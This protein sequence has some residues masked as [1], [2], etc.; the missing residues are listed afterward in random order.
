MKGL[1]KFLYALVLIFLLSA[2]LLLVKY[3][4]E[5]ITFPYREN[6]LDLAL[7]LK[8][9]NIILLGYLTFYLLKFLKALSHSISQNNLFSKN[10]GKAFHSIGI[11]LVFYSVLK[12]IISS[13]E[14]FVKAVQLESYS[15]GYILGDQIAARF[16]LLF[17][18]LFLLIISKL[19]IDGYELKKENELTI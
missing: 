18:A 1:L 14:E 17:L 6:A 11:A 15:I 3:S 7:I 19:M 2:I 13:I 8:T 9:F 10:N 16:P 5:M 4:Y 12:F